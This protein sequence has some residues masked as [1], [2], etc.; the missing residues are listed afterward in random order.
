M[1]ALAAPIPRKPHYREGGD[2][3]DQ[4]SRL[5]YT[6]EPT[7]LRS[8]LH[9]AS[10]IYN[11]DK[12]GELDG[13]RAEL[14]TNREIRRRIEAETGQRFSLSFINKGLYALHRVLGAK[15]LALIDRIRRHGR[16]VIRLVRGIRERSNA[17]QPGPGEPIIPPSTPPDPLQRQIQGTTTTEGPSSSSLQTSPRETERPDPAVVDALY[18][19]ARQLVDDVSRGDVRDA[20]EVFTAEWVGKALDVVERRNRKPGNARKPWGYV[21]GILLNRSK[22]GDWPDDP[23]PAPKAAAAKVA[24]E[25]AAAEKAAQDAEKARD[26][27]LRAAWGLLGDAQQD[28]IRATVLAANPHLRQLPPSML[29]AEC[30]EELGRRQAESP[31]PHRRE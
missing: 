14:L 11:A 19:R 2:L 1:T 8:A 24:P 5:I 27:R 26:E 13:D 9:V 23:A 3:Y 28:A 17:K 15:G 29:K 4:I 10:V 21:A 25:A 22:K 6:L 7:Y 18:D 12:R 16:R 20:V 31:G 30:L